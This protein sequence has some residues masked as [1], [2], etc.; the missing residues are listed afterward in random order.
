MTYNQIG[1]IND[2]DK[3]LDNTSTI[4]TANHSGELIKLCIIIRKA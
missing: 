2:N 4:G 3:R 1:L